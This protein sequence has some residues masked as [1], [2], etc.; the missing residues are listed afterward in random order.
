MALGDGAASSRAYARAAN[1]V[2]H[3]RTEKAEP[4]V[5]ARAL[6]IERWSHD[7]FDGAAHIL[8]EL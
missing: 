5:S 1:G 7:G 2:Q 6:P 8:Y 4:V 3:M